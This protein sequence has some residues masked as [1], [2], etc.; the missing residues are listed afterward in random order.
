MPTYELRHWEP[1]CS[2]LASCY[3]EKNACQNLQ[4]F[5]SNSF[6]TILA[7]PEEA[8]LFKQTYGEWF[9]SVIIDQFGSVRVD[10]FTWFTPALAT[11]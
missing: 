9:G 7:M 1:E 10:Q 6:R 8:K 5:L 4:K 11:W 2:K 3:N